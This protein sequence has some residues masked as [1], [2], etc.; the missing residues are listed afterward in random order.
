MSPRTL[1]PEEVDLIRDLL[2]DESK[3]SRTRLFHRTG[4]NSD[5][6]VFATWIKLANLF[7]DA[8]SVEVSVR[9]GTVTERGHPE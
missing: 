9:A 6:P 8:E 2:Y 5:R 4:E 7:R 3:S 1:T